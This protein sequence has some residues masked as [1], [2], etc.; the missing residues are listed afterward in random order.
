VSKSKRSKELDSFE[1]TKNKKSKKKEHK[2][3]A[4]RHN[5]LK[6]FIGEATTLTEED[7][8]EITGELED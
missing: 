5:D 2:K 4:K 3:R 8:E 1:A 6:E 7:W